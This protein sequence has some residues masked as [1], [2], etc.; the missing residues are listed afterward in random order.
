MLRELYY[1]FKKTINFPGSF[2]EKISVFSTLNRLLIKDSFSKN[3]KDKISVSFFGYKMYGYSYHTLYYLF[4][5][6]F[7]TNEYAFKTEV[8]E[9]LFIDCGANLG[10]SIL[11]F[12]KM[13]PDSKIIAFEANPRVFDLLSLNIK[14]NKLS[15]V[16]IHNLA[17]YSEEKEISFFAG[18]NTLEGSVISTR[19][20][21]N[22]IKVKATKLSNYLK[23]FDSVDLI[24]IDV[25]GAEKEIINDLFDSKTINKAK[26]YFI[27]YHH[28]I[29][30][31]ASN[32][33]T[34]LQRFELNG[35]RYNI[36]SNF[37]KSA[38]FQDI[39]IHLYK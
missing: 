5:E 17:L 14:E 16:S 33:S 1:S 28:N 27:E 32:L 20:G 11:Y 2:L 26:E 15:N 6:I 9:P 8:K 22:E 12:K 24:K 25:E 3:Q 39:L 30:G 10:M 23:D 18:D 38:S 31:E 37:N 34:F 4:N 21:Q 29:D 36:K 7:V 13:F 35:F 19:G